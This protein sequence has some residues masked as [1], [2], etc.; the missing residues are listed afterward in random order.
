MRTR[1]AAAVA[2]AAGIA[3][4]AGQ[5]GG[6]F[7]SFSGEVGDQTNLT[8]FSGGWVEAA[9][10]L[11]SPTVDGLGATISWTP[12]TQGVTG[13]ELWYIDR[14]TT[15]NCNSGTSNGLLTGGAI[16]AGTSSLAGTTGS[17]TDDVPSAKNGHYICYQVRSTHNVWWTAAT[18][19]LVQ[20][21]LVPISISSSN[22]G[23]SGVI[24][25]GDTITIDYNQ[26]IADSNG[27]VT[28]R[29]CTNGQIR[30]GST[31]CSAASSV[32]T[33]AG[34]TIAA[35]VPF[36]GSTAS[37]SGTQLTITLHGGAAGTTVSGTG[38]F[39]ASGSDVSLSAIPSLNACTAA[40]NCRPT[41]SSWSF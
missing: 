8:T 20:V 27:T 24:D 23:V 34:L 18:F 26:A 4:A 11:G 30:I 35:T 12:A 29:V 17:P 3:L 2:L 38:T 16:S 41:Q 37:V 25:N 15:A 5:A 22:G 32:G 6:T 21:G 7:S 36:A 40:A 13:Q 10:N 39:T 33:I 9:T 14:N 31:S 28:V 19:G 1:A